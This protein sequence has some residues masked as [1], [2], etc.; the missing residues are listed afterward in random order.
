MFREKHTLKISF[1]PA[2][3]KLLQDWAVGKIA[4]LSKELELE[5]RKELIQFYIAI[6]LAG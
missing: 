1:T 6:S 3:R 4:N 2:F 5:R